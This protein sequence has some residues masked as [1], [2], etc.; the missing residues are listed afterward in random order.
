[1][2]YEPQGGA[3]SNYAGCTEITETM[4]SLMF[5]TSTHPPET[6]FTIRVYAI[7][8]SLRSSADTIMANTVHLVPNV[9]SLDL[10]VSAANFGIH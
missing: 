7:R 8:D 3:E 10:H 1:M 6:N 4:C 5:N 2:S 9:V